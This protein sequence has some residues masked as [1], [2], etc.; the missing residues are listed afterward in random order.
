MLFRTHDMFHE[1]VAS[2]DVY[3]II[4]YYWMNFHYAKTESIKNYLPLDTD[5]VTPLLVPVI[6][7]SMFWHRI[8]GK[9]LKKTKTANK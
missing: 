9:R 7:M 5:K 2:W 6:C 1:S 8:S 3:L 4:W